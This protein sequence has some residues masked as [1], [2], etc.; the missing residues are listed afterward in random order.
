MTKEEVAEVDL[1][2]KRVCDMASYRCTKDDA[3]DIAE[4]VACEIMDL[5]EW[6]CPSH[7]SNGCRKDMPDAAYAT[8]RHALYKKVLRLSLLI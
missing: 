4:Y 7:C 3:A 2:T 5:A 6:M 8:A 1:H